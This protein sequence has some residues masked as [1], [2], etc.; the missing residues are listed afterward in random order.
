[1]APS[2][3]VAGFVEYFCRYAV[4]LNS[5]P[6]PAPIG[7]GAFGASRKARSCAAWRS[8]V[9]ARSPLRRYATPS[10][11][12]GWKD[13]QCKRKSSWFV[14]LDGFF[15][16]RNPPTLRR[17]PSSGVN[18]GFSALPYSSSVFLPRYWAMLCLASCIRR[19][20]SR[21]RMISSMMGL[22]PASPQLAP[23]AK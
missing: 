21:S 1:M 3:V 17:Q 23:C 15:V 18:T 19:S 9:A 7:R 22:A 20:L 12:S 16:Y 8:F 2:G 5:L 13:A 4:C 11:T 14:P 6:N 10:P